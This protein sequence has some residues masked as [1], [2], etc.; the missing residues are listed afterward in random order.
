MIVLNLYGSF[1]GRSFTA[2]KRSWREQGSLLQGLALIEH[3]L[4]GVLL[5]GRRA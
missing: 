5:A 4:S 1:F 3:F 2:G